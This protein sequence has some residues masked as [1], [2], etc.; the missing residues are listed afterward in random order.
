MSNKESIWM[1]VLFDSDGK[2]IRK[3]FTIDFYE[4]EVTKI[5]DDVFVYGLDANEF[6]LSLNKI[7]AYADENYSDEK[8]KFLYKEIEI[9]FKALI[10]DNTR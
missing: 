4:A 7:Q 3:G 9:D 5:F 2:V 1:W 10:E 8:F 6:T